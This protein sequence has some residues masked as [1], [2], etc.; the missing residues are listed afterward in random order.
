M[1]DESVIVSW[2]LGI[3]EKVVNLSG[4]LFKPDFVCFETE[5]Q[6]IY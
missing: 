4:V 3:K 6:L 2:E 5:L 1:I